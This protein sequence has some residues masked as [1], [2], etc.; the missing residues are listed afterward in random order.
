MAVNIIPIQGTFD[1]ARGR[2]LLRTQ[3]ANENWHPILWARGAAL[4]TAIGELILS[5]QTTYAIPLEVSTVVDQKHR[6]L[7]M[8]CT[9][10]LENLSC[11]MFNTLEERIQRAA[12]Q[13][14][15]NRQLNRACIKAHLYPVREAH[16]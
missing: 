2:N 12:D 14:D 9:V 15:V 8:S 11:E 5:T 1:I 6:E 4:L 3:M 13:I 10:S 16:S 7:Y